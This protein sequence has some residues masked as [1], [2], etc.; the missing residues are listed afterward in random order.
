M[1]SSQHVKRFSDVNKPTM[2]LV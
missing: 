1:I 2:M